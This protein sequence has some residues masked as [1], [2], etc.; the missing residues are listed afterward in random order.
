MKGKRPN[1]E[2]WAAA[3]LYWETHPRVTCRE[4]AEEALGGP[5]TRT[6]RR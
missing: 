1:R 6:G 2:Q 5:A 3:R 4:V